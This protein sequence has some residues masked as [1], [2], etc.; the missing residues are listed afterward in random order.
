MV[1]TSPLYD[2]IQLLYT[3]HPN[4]TNQ[5]YIQIS[6]Y[7]KCALVLMFALTM[8]FSLYDCIHN[9]IYFI[10]FTMLFLFSKYS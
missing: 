9:K 3:L 7:S 2:F 1:L 6:E 4:P 10:P 8:M 5:Y